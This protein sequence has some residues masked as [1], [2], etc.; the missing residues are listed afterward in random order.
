MVEHA[1]RRGI[2]LWRARNNPHR[3]QGALHVA[4]VF[5]ILSG[6]GFEFFEE[7]DD[8]SHAGGLQDTLGVAALE[9]PVAIARGDLDF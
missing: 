9:P 5:D 6:G 8:D 1:R 4:F 2:Q 3:S 7:V